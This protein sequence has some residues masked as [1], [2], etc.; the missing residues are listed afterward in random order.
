VKTFYTQQQTADAIG[1]LKKNGKTIG[2]VPTMGALHQGHLS[3]IE[4]SKKE[5]DFTIVSIFVNPIQFNNSNDLVNYPRT[6]A[7]DSKLLE[8]INT[9]FLFAPNEKEM[10][11][12]TPSERYDFGLLETVMEGKFRQGHFNG[13]A[14]VVKR[15]FDICTP[16]KAYFGMKDFQQLAIIQALVETKKIPVEIVP[17]PTVRE[18]D[19][20][21]MSSRN[22]RLS[23]QQRSQATIISKALFK[24]QEQFTNITV[25]GLKESIRDQIDSMPEMKT[26]YVEI[27]NS[28]TLQ[29]LESWDEACNKT[30]CIAAWAGEVRLID[31]LQL[32]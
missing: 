16:D 14:V 21:A 1:K 26:E 3:L 28:K 10:Y 29:S 6:L 24:A 8:N 31:N 22:K 17:C 9:D 15:L 25:N 19:G 12:E 32:T 4:R 20:L 30:I 5:N 27:V 23:E 13:V 7:E 18:N 11:P 2:F